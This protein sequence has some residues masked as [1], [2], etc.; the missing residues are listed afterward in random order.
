MK[1]SLFLLCFILNGCWYSNGCF[2]TPQ[3]VNCVDKGKL[4]PA[5]VKIPIVNLAHQRMGKQVEVNVFGSTS[6]PII[7]ERGKGVVNYNPIRP[8][9]GASISAPT[10]I[11]NSNNSKKEDK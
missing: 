2:Y 3:M 11:I 5:I 7:Y 10:T 6:I 8:F 9:A 4:W 1:Y